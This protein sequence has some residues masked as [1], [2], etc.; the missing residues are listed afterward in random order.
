MCY[1]EAARLGALLQERGPPFFPGKSNAFLLL[2]VARPQVEHC[3]EGL[4]RHPSLTAAAAGGAAEGAW[5]MRAFARGGQALLLDPASSCNDA[6]ICEQLCAALLLCVN[7]G[8]PVL[9]CAAGEGAPGGGGSYIGSWASWL[10]SG[11]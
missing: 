8:T 10:G 11:S 9:C 1:L 6:P 5:G 7:A 3:K 2:I 4:A